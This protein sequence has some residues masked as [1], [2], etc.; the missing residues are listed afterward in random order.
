VKRRS[1]GRGPA[2][3]RSP[4]VKLLSR[5]SVAAALVL[6]GCA[7]LGGLVLG[8][9]HQ[10]TGPGPKPPGMDGKAPAKA[11][12]L[13]PDTLPAFLK[14]MGLNPETHKPKEGQPFCSFVVREDDG[15]TFVVEASVSDG[16]L[17]LLSPLGDKLP[18]AKSLSAD[19]LLNLLEANHAT[20]P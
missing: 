20:A 5:K 13:T 17:W 3:S 18:E 19:H 11:D 12:Q 15:W 14:E 2:F 16:S 1:V 9:A 7:V 8:Q 4:P 10:K 6:A